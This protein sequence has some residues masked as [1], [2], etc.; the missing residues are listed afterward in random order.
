[1]PVA[2][3]STRIQVDLDRANSQREGLLDGLGDRQ[4]TV[5][6]RGDTGFSGLSQRD[7]SLVSHR[8][9]GTHMASRRNVQESLRRIEDRG[10]GEHKGVVMAHIPV[11]NPSTSLD[12]NR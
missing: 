4:R 1:M 12:P 3:Q 9:T 8:R 2:A 7:N 6:H 10:I 5:M 11:R